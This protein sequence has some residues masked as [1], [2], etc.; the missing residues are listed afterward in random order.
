MRKNTLDT[1]DIVRIVLIVVFILTMIISAIIP[2]SAPQNAKSQYFCNVKVFA[3][4][5]NIDIENMS[6][7][8]LYNVKGEYFY[9]F[10]DDLTMKNAEENVVREMKDNYNFITQNDH[11]ITNSNGALYAMKGNFKWFGDSYKILNSNKEQVATLECNMFMTSCVLKD[12]QDNV[13][14]KY[15]SRIFR[16]D[17]IVSIYDDCAIDDESVLLMFAS[18]YSDVRADDSSND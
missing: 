18:A 7:E 3:L 10:E 11:V 17:Y 6:N 13:V 1:V 4:A 12:M 2:L 15:N 16:R 8:V 9:T 14:A 5:L